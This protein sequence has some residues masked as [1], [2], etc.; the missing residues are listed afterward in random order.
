MQVI[1]VD[2]EQ[3]NEL[4][5]LSLDDVLSIEPDMK[6]T[7]GHLPMNLS[8]AIEA[9]RGCCG[10]STDSEGEGSRQP[11]AWQRICSLM[12]KQELVMRLCQRWS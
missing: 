11:T 3:A 4:L 9:L 10:S 2:R 7:D 8:V 1:N 5:I 6:T 12:Q